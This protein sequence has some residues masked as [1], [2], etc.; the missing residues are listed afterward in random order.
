MI[1]TEW[2]QLR[3]CWFAYNTDDILAHKKG[4]SEAN[5]VARIK[6]AATKTGFK[7]SEE[8]MKAIKAAC[9]PPS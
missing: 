2:S 5:A 9:T 8:D 3:K 1:K 4:V 6:H 7:L